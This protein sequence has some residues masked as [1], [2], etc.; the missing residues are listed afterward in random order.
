[1]EKRGG[2]RECKRSS[3][4]VWEKNKYRSKT[5]KEVGYDREKGL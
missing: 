2:L 3:N 4:I 1:M 5:T